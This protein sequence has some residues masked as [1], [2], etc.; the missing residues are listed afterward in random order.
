VDLINAKLGRVYVDSRWAGLGTSELAAAL[1]GF[2]VEIDTGVHPKFLGA[3]SRLFTSHGIGA[4][5]GTMKLTLERTAGVA[6]EELYYR[7]ASGY[8]QTPRF[9]Q[10]E[11]TDGTNVL[12]IDMAGVWTDWES[13]SG[14]VE[15]NTIDVATLT[16]GYDTTGTQAIQVTVVCDV[17]SV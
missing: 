11:I 8:A 6:A 16:A 9:V 4:I 3:A 7:P 5:L 12:T 1:V 10:L 14:D 13:L 17:A 15:G 2:D